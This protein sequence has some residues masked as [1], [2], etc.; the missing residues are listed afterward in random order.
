MFDSSFNDD[1]PRQ[2]L[3]ELVD[4]EADAGSVQRACAA[5]RESPSMRASWHA[6]HLIGDVLRSDDLAH[7]VERDEA[8]LASLR[9]RLA[10][11][12]VVL[13]PAAAAAADTPRRRRT[14]AAPAAMAA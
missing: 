13:A 10:A 4:G 2:R 9:S 7:P 1:D 14:W 12:P 8:F 5:W 6:Y 3:S 11:E